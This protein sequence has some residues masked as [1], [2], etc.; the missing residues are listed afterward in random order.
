MSRAKPSS[1]WGPLTMS[2]AKANVRRKVS[3]LH[4]VTPEMEEAGCDKARIWRPSQRE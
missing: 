1:K 2:I 4:M 3:K